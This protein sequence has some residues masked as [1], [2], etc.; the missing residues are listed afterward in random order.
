MHLLACANCFL[1][2]SVQ[3]VPLSVNLA[4]ARK[5]QALRQEERVEEIISRIAW[6]ERPLL[7]RGR[8]STELDKFVSPT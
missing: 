5:R 3:F 1:S 6:I 2:C 8:I 4:S 7:V